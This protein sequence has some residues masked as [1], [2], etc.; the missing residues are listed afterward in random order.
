MKRNDALVTVKTKLEGAVIVEPQVHGD[1]RGWFYESYSKRKYEQ[2]GIVADFVQDNRSYS[3]Q[4]GIIRGL[5]CQLAPHAQAKLLT[6]IK[7][8]ILDV[9]VDAREGS[10]TYLQWVSVELSAENKRQF[11]IPR[12]FLH[13]FLTLTDEVEVMYKADNY[14]EPTSDRSICWND[15]AIGV[16]WGIDNPVLSA[17]D[18]AAPLL[19]LSDVRF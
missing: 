11:F 8:A 3:S 18:S 10:P 7:G 4:K 13:G 6:C 14:Y 16:D 12:G 17:K 9:A 15:P 5:H 19:A 2:L 1:A